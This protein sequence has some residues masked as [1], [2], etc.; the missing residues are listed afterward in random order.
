[1]LVVTSVGLLLLV[2]ITTV[3]AAAVGSSEPVLRDCRT[4]VVRRLRDWKPN[5]VLVGPLDS[6]RA[7]SYERSRSIYLKSVGNGQYEGLKLLSVV[8]HG[9]EGEDCGV[10][11]RSDRRSR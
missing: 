1:M 7:R 8:S 5:S 10:G 3:G 4:S 6:C 2:T 11:A 9:V